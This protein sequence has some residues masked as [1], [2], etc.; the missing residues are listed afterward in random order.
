[1]PLTDI[2][3][4]KAQSKYKPYKLADGGGLYIE[5]ATS[6]GKLWRMKYRY[7]GKEKRLSF[8]SYP[9]ISL[10]DARKR[11]DD[12]KQLLAN[13]TD[14][15]EVK[16]IKKQQRE[17]ASANSF[18]AVTRDWLAGKYFTNLVVSSRTKKISQ[19]ERYVFSPTEY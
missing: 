3:I 18:E 16:R 15:S 7:A 6:G 1:M 4:R 19:L 12:A 5:I 2:Q 14:P 9:T 13:D 8:G 11:R 10:A 17:I